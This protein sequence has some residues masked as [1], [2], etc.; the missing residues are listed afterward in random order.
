MAL[1]LIPPGKR[2]NSW[3][4]RIRGRV[5]GMLHEF[6]T[7]TTLRADAELMLHRLEIELRQKES[8]ARPGALTFAAGAQLWINFKN[9]KKVD[10]A[11]I[12]R[13]NAADIGGGVLLGDK[14]IADVVHADLVAAANYLFPGVRGTKK[15]PWR[16]HSN[17]T[18][19][20]EALRPAA[21]VLHY[22]AENGFCPWRKIKSFEEPEP[23]TRA[24]SI[25]MAT[26][27]LANLPTE[28]PKKM[29]NRPATAADLARFAER[30]RKKKLLLLCLFR[31]GWRISDALKIE[32]PQFDLR[33]QTVTYH[34]GKTDRHDRVKP[35]HDEVLELLAA[36]PVASRRG[37]VF[38]WRTRSGV[39]KWLR[40]YCRALGIKFTPHMA[41]H[42]L[43]KWL[44]E[45]RANIREIMDTLDHASVVSSARYQS[46][47]VEVLR[48]SGRR[49]GKLVGGK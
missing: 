18:K 35:I 31:Q 2:K 36:E 10:R 21:S 34:V 32:W 37:R 39:Y 8:A 33:A 1:H 17:A 26:I 45:D 23:V 27:I 11:R 42:S 19:N 40:P 22:C 6:R 3:D 47:D 13:L 12:A 15:R 48:A 16:P 25:D 44:N 29:G 49:L 9:P 20:R 7:K 24:I 30:A 28:A 41:R 4:Y 5:K 14:L 46:T 38:P 43:G